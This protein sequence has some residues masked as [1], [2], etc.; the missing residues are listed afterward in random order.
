MDW[1]KKADYLV[2][3]GERESLSKIQLGGAHIKLDMKSEDTVDLG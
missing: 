2:G 3:K 1:L